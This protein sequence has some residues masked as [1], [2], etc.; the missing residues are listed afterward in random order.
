MTMITFSDVLLKQARHIWRCKIFAAPFLKQNHQLSNPSE[1]LSI[2]TSRYPGRTK[3]LVQQALH[4]QERIDWD[5]T[6]RRYLSLTKGLFEAPHEVTN[7][8]NKT[9]QSSA[10][11]ILTLI[12]LGTF[13]KAMW[14]DRCTKLHDPNNTSSPTS[15]LDADIANC[16]ANPQDLLAAD[17]PT[18]SPYL[19]G[20]QIQTHS[21]NQVSSQHT[22][23]PLLLSCRA[24]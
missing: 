15:D 5:K 1:P 23:R 16:Y 14:K 2:D 13:S 17:G 12:N 8:Y 3:L 6:F 11:V 19:E 9:P 22:P 20:P 21:Q 10:W 4:E 24:P 18:Q 7:P